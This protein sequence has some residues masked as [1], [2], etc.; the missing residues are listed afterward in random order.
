MEAPGGVASLGYVEDAFDECENDS[1]RAFFS[2]MP[3]R[4]PGRHVKHP[5]WQ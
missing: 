2:V 3:A 5:A 4:P 1:W